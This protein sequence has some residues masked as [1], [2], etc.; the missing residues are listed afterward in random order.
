MSAP[1]AYPAVVMP[2]PL[3]PDETLLF[4]LTADKILAVDRKRRRPNGKDDAIFKN[5]GTPVGHLDSPSSLAAV[6]KNGVLTVYGFLTTIL[7]TAVTYTVSQVSPILNPLGASDDFKT[8]A[9]TGLAAVA[10]EK[11][12]S[13]WVYFLKRGDATS[14]NAVLCEAHDQDGI[15]DYTVHAFKEVHPTNTTSLGAVYDP[16]SKARIVFLQTI[17][18]GAPSPKIRFLYVTNKY[19]ISSNEIIGFGEDAVKVG[20]PLEAVYRKLNNEGRVYVYFLNVNSELYFI[21]SPLPKYND[22]QPVAAF[23]WSAPQ[24]LDTEKA[25]QGSRISV[26][27][28]TEHNHIYYIKANSEKPVYVSY[29]HAL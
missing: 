24:V 15:D 16:D 8:S 12:P 7:G 14:D 2:N 19:N 18:E 17:L 13:A 29:S 25:A 5:N 11:G 10:E 6:T 23:R 20:T 4:Y 28:D 9:P 3:V 1:M 21:S 26:K 27:P 22:P